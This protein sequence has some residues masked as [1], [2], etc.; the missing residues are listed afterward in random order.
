MP[1]LLIEIF[2]EYSSTTGFRLTKRDIKMYMG[3]D[4]SVKKEVEI[5]IIRFAIKIVTLNLLIEMFNKKRVIECN[6]L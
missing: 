4:V 6:A 3:C 2:E 1:L 5:I